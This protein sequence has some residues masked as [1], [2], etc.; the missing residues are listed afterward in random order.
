M[1]MNHIQ[2]GLSLKKSSWG[3]SFPETKVREFIDLKQNSLIVHKY[4]F[5]LSR[6]ALDMVKDI[7]S[8]M[9]LFVLS[10]GRASSKES[11]AA[12]LIGK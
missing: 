8:K 11:R 9:S 7:R 6:Y 10:L 12:M 2:V 4:G 1:R 5:L 3:G